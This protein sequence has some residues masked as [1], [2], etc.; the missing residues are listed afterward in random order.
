MQW[1]TRIMMTPAGAV[2]TIWQLH[3]VLLQALAATY[4]GF[5][6]TLYPLSVAYANDYI[7][8]KDMVQATGGLVLAFGIG[9]ALGPISAA[10]VMKVVGPAG[11]FIFT[12]AVIVLVAAFI[13]YRMR[14]RQWVPVAEKESFV[15]MPEATT[16]PVAMEFD[17]R[18]E[19]S[20]IELPLDD[21]DQRPGAGKR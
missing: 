17:P 8:P 2:S 19:C 4:G 12:G 3:P 9:A 1:D 13:I 16:T 21:L 11:L 15:L 5:V 18:T 20:Q 6:A 10:A 7:E 14:C